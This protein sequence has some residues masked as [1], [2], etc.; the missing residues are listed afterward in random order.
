DFIRVAAHEPRQTGYLVLQSIAPY[1]AT[2]KVF[3]RILQTFRIFVLDVVVIPHA[4][5]QIPLN[6]ISNGLQ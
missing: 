1:A 4:L 3:A 2:F 6:P 5:F